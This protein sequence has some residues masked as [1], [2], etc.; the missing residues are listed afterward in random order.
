METGTH[1]T[2]FT[3]LCV[4]KDLLSTCFLIKSLL[5]EFLVNLKMLPNSQ[6]LFAL[7]IYLWEFFH[8]LDA[9][10]LGDIRWTYQVPILAAIGVS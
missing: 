2:F 5:L 3:S 9:G 7:L 4:L 8:M 6:C 10:I 1:Y